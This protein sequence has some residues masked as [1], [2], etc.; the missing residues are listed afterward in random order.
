MF[1][2]FKLYCKATIII[3]ALAKRHIGQWNRI[4]SPEINI[5]SYMVNQFIAKEPRIYNG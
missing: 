2:D 1:P 3:T 5:Y 4:D